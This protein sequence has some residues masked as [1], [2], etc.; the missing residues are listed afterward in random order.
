MMGGLPVVVVIYQVNVELGCD[1]LLSLR[2][3][4]LGAYRDA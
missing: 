4:R 3:V 1:E 2:P